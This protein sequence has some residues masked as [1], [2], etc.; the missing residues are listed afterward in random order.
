MKATWSY[1]IMLKC[2]NVDNERDVCGLKD[3]KLSFT[4]CTH[5]HFSLTCNCD[6]D[7]SSSWELRI[8]AVIVL[9]A[10][11]TSSWL[12]PPAAPRRACR[13]R[14]ENSSCVNA[15]RWRD[16]EGRGNLNILCR[17]RSVAERTCGPPNHT[18]LSLTHQYLVTIA[19]CCTLMM[20]ETV[21]ELQHNVDTVNEGT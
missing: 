4:L 3:R 8:T 6:S 7:T 15:A 2:T 1:Q 12:V 9:K 5:P 14:I 18:A 13:P 20:V 16:S 17:H 10:V 19:L 11:S 21:E